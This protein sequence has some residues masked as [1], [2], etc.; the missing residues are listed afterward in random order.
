MAT[1]L[2]S[3]AFNDRNAAEVC[4]VTSTEDVKPPVIVE[5]S[6]TR[7]TK[8]KRRSR[9]EAAED[10]DGCMDTLPCKVC[11]DRASGIHYG[12]TTCEG[13][14]GFFRRSQN[15]LVNYQ[16]PR[17]KNCTI[18]RVT[19]NRCQF[20]RLQKCLELGMSREA[21][22][23]GR[24][25]KKQRE[26]V[27]EEDSPAAYSPF[28]YKYAAGP[29]HLLYPSAANTPLGATY[30]LYQQQHVSPL[31]AYPPCTTM[32]PSMPP[33]GLPQPT[34]VAAMPHAYVP[35]PTHGLAAAAPYRYAA[36]AL[37]TYPIAHVG[38]IPPG[39]GAYPPEYDMPHADVSSTFDESLVKNVVSA[40]EGA[41]QI[42]LN[43]EGDDRGLSVMEKQQA[44]MSMDR[45]RGWHKF[46]NEITKV[47]KFIIEFAK[48][49]RYFT[50]IDN[51][52][53]VNLLKRSAFELA[54]IAM[55]MHYNVENRTLTVDDVH[56]PIDSFNCHDATDQ[57]F[58]Q[59]LLHCIETLA[60]FRLN[61]AEVALLSAIVLMGDTQQEF[62]EKM[63]EALYSEFAARFEEGPFPLFK[64]L[65]DQ[66]IRLRDVGKQHL[67]ALTRFQ[68]T[69]PEELAQELPPL[70]V[71]CFSHEGRVNGGL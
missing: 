36:N 68:H 42:Y 23:F 56:L 60:T 40:Y 50:D 63:R 62:V 64:R 1:R 70:Y 20:C 13:C 9:N 5:A 18:D 35:Q 45:I 8:R 37:P 12:V 57:K 7:P 30:D 31:S 58:G 17:Q 19:R 69:V 66:V 48:S 22:K 51:G 61:S 27:E 67:V 54:V 15:A 3:A 25:S 32:P 29:P 53:Q 16:C 10:A 41:H 43:G 28:D 52:D 71:E 47:I 44:F 46:A 38:Q 49:I 21:V 11:G 2:P 4:D 6:A 39:S 33:T 59:E 14:K 26:K 55:S 34:S 24:M 65:W